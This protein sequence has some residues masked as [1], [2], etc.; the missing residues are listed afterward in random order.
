MVS[1][2]ELAA[3]CV[4]ESRAAGRQTDGREKLSFN[5]H[6]ATYESAVLFAF[7][8]GFADS[9]ADWLAASVVLPLDMRRNRKNFYTVAQKFFTLRPSYS[10]M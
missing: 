7:L 2:I 5:W 1:W 8:P 6:S 10:A 9:F 3:S 4:Q